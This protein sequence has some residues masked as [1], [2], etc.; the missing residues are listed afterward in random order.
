MTD[1]PSWEISAHLIILPQLPGHALY[2]PVTLR[3]YVGSW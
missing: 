1:I 2:N 3:V